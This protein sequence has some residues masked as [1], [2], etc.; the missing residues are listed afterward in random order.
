M[1]P[2]T[3]CRLERMF[4]AIL[5]FEMASYGGVP[6]GMHVSGYFGIETRN[7]KS[8]IQLILSWQPF[9]PSGSGEIYN[10]GFVTIVS[11]KELIVSMKGTAS[12]AFSAKVR[13]LLT[14]DCN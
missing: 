13:R 4:R 14:H 9:L 3:G 10:F 5:A 8:P 2:R 7:S 11:M 1:A 12:V 6:F